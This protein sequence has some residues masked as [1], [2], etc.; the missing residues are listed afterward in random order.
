MKAAGLMK[1]WVTGLDGYV[2]GRMR[3]G[4]VKLA[5]NENNYG[6][7]PKVI[8]EIKKW[9]RRAYIYP[10]RDDEVVEGAAKYAGVGTEN[11]VPGNG[12]DEIIELIL[13]T[14]KGP[15]GSI[16]PT[17]SEYRLFSEAVGEEYVSSRLGGGFCFDAGR[18]IRETQ[19]ANILFLCSP[20]NP[21]GGVI[22]REDVAKVA[23]TGKIV[24]VDEAYWEFSGEKSAACLVSEYENLIVMRTLSKAFGLAGGRFG[25]AIANPEIAKVML[26]IKAPFSV[27]L[28]TQAAAIAAF[29]DTTHM[30]KCARSIREDTKLVY[31]ELSRRFKACPTRSNFVF[32]DTS[33]K[34]T[35]K[36]FFDRMLEKM[37]IVRSFG[38]VEGFA[39]EYSR[40]SAG[41]R[42]ETKKF[43]K[44]LK[45]L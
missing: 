3:E 9:A 24:V 21:T 16:S 26:K 36:E 22:P 6:P 14:F 45:E 33:P 5:S 4:F 35:S 31:K 17:Y 23:E 25:Y 39:G 19:R 37:I 41:T 11:I 44:A 34:Y 10:Y 13:K 38:R 42:E 7:S 20:N 1:P 15:V 8:A 30:R 32:F 29:K 2:P 43:V 27:S 40:V 18:F 12:S 28:I